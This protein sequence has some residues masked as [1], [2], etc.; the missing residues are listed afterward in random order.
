MALPKPKVKQDS[1][2]EIEAK[3][4]AMATDESTVLVKTKGGAIVEALL[5]TTYKWSDGVE[6]H[7]A[8]WTKPLSEEVRERLVS[9]GTEWAFYWIYAEDADNLAT[10]RGKGS[11]E[12]VKNKENLVYCPYAVGAKT[13]GYIH[14]RGNMLHKRSRELQERERANLDL[15]LSHQRDPKRIKNEID[16]AV[17]GRVPTTIDVEA[18][19]SEAITKGQSME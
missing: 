5:T 11:W 14:W 12:P 3:Q 9:G 17:D 1:E 15:Y 7:F 8:P 10:K 19:P 2:Q 16:A 6:R 13:D 4:M 18:V